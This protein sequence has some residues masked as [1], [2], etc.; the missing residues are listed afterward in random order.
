VCVC[1][2][3]CGS[4]ITQKVMDGFFLNFEGISGVA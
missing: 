4:K 1:V 2:C 3:M